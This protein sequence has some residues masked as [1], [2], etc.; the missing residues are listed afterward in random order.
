MIKL[1][2]LNIW[3]KHSPS[4]NYFNGLVKRWMLSRDYV[5]IWDQHWAGTSEDTRPGKSRQIAIK[6]PNRLHHYLLQWSLYFYKMHPAVSIKYHHFR[7][8]L[9]D[10]HFSTIVLYFTLCV[11]KAYHQRCRLRWRL[12]RRHYYRFL[13]MVRFGALNDFL[14][15][16]WLIIYWTH[17]EHITT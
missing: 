16:C 2:I 1:L 7:A 3:L 15:H 13:I 5:M 8:Y 9:F 11:P 12:R 4:K 6:C 10:T 17:N 14:N